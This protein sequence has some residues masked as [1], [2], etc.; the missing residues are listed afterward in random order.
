MNFVILTK[1]TAMS[2]V[3]IFTSIKKV[4][5]AYKQRLAEISDTDFQLS[6]Q[7][8]DWSSSEVYQHIFDLSALSLDELDNCIAGRGK[9]VRT[10]LVTYLILFFGRFPPAIKFKVPRHLESRVKKV[11]KDEASV[12][13]DDF[14][15]KLQ[16]YSKKLEQA[17][18]NIKTPHP[19]LGFLNAK[20]W[21]RFIEIHLRHHFEQ[22]NH[23]DKSF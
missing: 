16:P 4:T 19:R 13:I 1:Q 23:I 18:P 2:S 5:F 7:N 21:L 8:N 11:T 3:Q 20:Q 15:L 9:K 10:H 14:L 6:P 22:L 17:S 12:M